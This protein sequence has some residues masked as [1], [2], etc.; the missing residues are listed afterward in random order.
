M[1][2]AQTQPHDALIS[3]DLREDQVFIRLP[4]DR[5]GF[6]IGDFQ[7]QW[8]AFS[9]D[10]AKTPSGPTILAQAVVAAPKAM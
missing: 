2:S 5:E 3:V 1:Q 7:I 6:D 8:F 10:R 9:R 4:V